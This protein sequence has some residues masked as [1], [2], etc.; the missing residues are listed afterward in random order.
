[1]YGYIEIHAHVGQVINYGSNSLHTY[2]QTHTLT[3]PPTPTHTVHPTITSRS[4][5]LSCVLWPGHHVRAVAMIEY[6]QSRQPSL[7]PSRTVD[8]LCKLHQSL[9]S[10]VSYCVHVQKRIT[11]MSPIEINAQ[12]KLSNQDT[13]G[14]RESV[15][16]SE[17]SRFQGS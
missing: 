9:Y 3:H 11:W 12:W 14:T 4:H 13:L 6:Q 16:I 1:M 17:V 10:E 7:S 8:T 2:N 5:S 15:L